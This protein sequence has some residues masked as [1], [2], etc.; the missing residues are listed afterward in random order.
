[1]FLT[2]QPVFAGWL[3]P[4]IVNYTDFSWRGKSISCGNIESQFSFLVVK[5]K[6]HKCNILFL[7]DLFEKNHI[8][9]NW[10]VKMKLCTYL[11]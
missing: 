3:N 9:Q 6:S 5:H 1:M 7:S 2:H 8:T 10:V 4:K 11:S